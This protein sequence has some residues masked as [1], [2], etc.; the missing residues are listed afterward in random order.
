MNDLGEASCEP[1][2]EDLRER[3]AYHRVR[4]IRTQNPVKA[5]EYRDIADILDQEA[6]D[7]QAEEAARVPM[8]RSA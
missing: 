3:A 7:Q 1:T 5:A 4:A 6:D 8:K 2:V